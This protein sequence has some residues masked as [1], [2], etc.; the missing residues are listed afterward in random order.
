MPDA[1]CP[2]PE[3]MLPAQDLL[4]LRMARTWSFD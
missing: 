4:A 1:R 3:L 2:M